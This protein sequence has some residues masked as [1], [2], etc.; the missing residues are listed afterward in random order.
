MPSARRRRV[1]TRAARALLVLTA[2][3]AVAMI[4]LSS[5]SA[6]TPPYSLPVV[7]PATVSSP[8]FDAAAPYTPAV[9]TLIAQ[10]ESGNPP[11]QADLANADK[12][13]HDGPSPSCHN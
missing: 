6:S 11:S 8:S 2:T 10:L 4:V 7:L 13:L 1:G 9:L 12:L 3:A 5:A